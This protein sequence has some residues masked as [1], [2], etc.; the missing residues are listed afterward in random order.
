MTEKQQGDTI[1]SRIIGLLKKGY[2]RSQLITDFNL[3]ERTVDAGIKE[4]KE[5]YRDSPDAAKQTK[6]NVE[7]KA[8][9]LPAKV[10]TGEGVLPE[11]IATEMANIF[12]GSER[13]RRIYLAGVATP[14]MGVR[15]IQEMVKP[16][17]DMML[18]MRKE[19]LEAVM[20]AQGMAKEVA[21]RAAEGVGAQ[22]V[23]AL[24]QQRAASTNPMQ[25][26]MA[27][28]FRQPLSQLMAKMMGMFMQQP[29][30]GAP[31]PYNQP[32]LSGQPAP[33]PQTGFPVS[34]QSQISEEEIKE[35]FND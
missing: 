35:V 6:S 3:P 30:P 13:D 5:L 12:D 10:K 22:V 9:T 14:L 31:V 24:S 4:Y 20:E 29:Q 21:D 23:Q 1:K 28:M 17:T 27:D 33:Q 19:E 25:Q 8:E 32:G 34:D 18:A 26:L 7:T 15:L 11:W 16:L 2:T